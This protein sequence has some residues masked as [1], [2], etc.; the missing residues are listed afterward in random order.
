MSSLLSALDVDD[1][2][3]VADVKSATTSTSFCALDV[4]VSK[5]SVPGT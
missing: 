3:A 2:N 1:V 5:K 4:A